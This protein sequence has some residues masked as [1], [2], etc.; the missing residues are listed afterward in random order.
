MIAAA[1]IPALTD[2][3]VHRF[4]PLRVILFGSHARGDAQSDSD[5]DLLVHAGANQPTVVLLPGERQLR[6]GTA[7]LTLRFEH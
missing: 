6:R 1:Y 4:N 7:E 5:I 3:I 2:R